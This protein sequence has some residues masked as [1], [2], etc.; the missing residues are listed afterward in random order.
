LPKRFL[1]NFSTPSTSLAPF[2]GFEK[3]LTWSRA[4][5]V[6]TAANYNLHLSVLL[7]G[8]RGVGKFAAASWVAQQL[9]FHLLEVITF[10]YLH[11]MHIF[12]LF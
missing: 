7:K 8:A 12:T 9:G 10:S 4:A 6:V 5:L 11:A 2:G 1:K 3:L